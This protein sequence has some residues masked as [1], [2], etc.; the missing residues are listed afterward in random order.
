MV[1]EKVERTKSISCLIVPKIDAQSLVISL[2]R[3]G[4][5]LSSGSACSS[6]TPTPSHVL[7]AYGYSEEESLKA[8]RVSFGVFNSLEEVEEVVLKIKKTFEKIYKFS[9]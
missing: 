6:G 3:Q 1:S 4:V 7:L 2:G 8:I 5:Y 9:F